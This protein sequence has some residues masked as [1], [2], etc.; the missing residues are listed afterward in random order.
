MTLGVRVTW[1]AMK[2]ACADIRSHC[3]ELTAVTVQSQTQTPRKP[4]AF[5][6]SAKHS[7]SEKLLTPVATNRLNRLQRT[8]IAS[9]AQD[10][11]NPAVESPTV[12]LPTSGAKRL[13]GSQ[14]RETSTLDR[15]PRSGLMTLDRPGRY[16]RFLVLICCVEDTALLIPWPYSPDL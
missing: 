14:P 12:L 5:S 4:T 11:S 8:D 13:F 9:V 3:T 10:C 7:K 6:V 1:S 15:L 2:C 16:G